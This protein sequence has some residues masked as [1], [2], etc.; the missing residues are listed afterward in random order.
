[1]AGNRVLR[2]RECMYGIAAKLLKCLNFSV[3]RTGHA[4][5]I[6][7]QHIISSENAADAQEFGV[8]GGSIVT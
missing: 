4:A 3:Q 1:M 5:C 8:P 2:S 7:N 6:F